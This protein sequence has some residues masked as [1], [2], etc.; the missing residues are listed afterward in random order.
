MPQI[1]INS[2]LVFDVFRKFN[3]L[4]LHVSKSNDVSEIY[5]YAIKLF[6][7]HIQ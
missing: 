7:G 4:K 3:H 6:L 1:T 5:V 2:L